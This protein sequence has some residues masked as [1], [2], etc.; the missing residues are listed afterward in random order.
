MIAFRAHGMHCSTG[1]APRKF[2]SWSKETNYKAKHIPYDITLRWATRLSNWTLIN[3]AYLVSGRKRP[4]NKTQPCLNCLN[5]HFSQKPFSSKCGFTGEAGYGFHRKIIPN[6]PSSI[7]F[8][9]Q[10]YWTFY[11][12]KT[13]LIFFQRTTMWCRLRL[14]LCI[15]IHY[16]HPLISPKMKKKTRR[17][18]QSYVQA[19]FIRYVNFKAIGLHDYSVPITMKKN[20]LA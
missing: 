19:A 1:H 5:R 16:C 7:D 20:K 8:A 6:L 3:K 17:R 4:T 9:F 11:L 18:N 2:A 14:N 10:Q 12:R 15:Q 13:I